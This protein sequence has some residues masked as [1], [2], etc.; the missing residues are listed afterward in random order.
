MK[1]QNNDYRILIVDSSLMIVERLN[2]MLAEMNCS[3]CVSAAFT[4]GE[5]LEKLS[6]NTYDIVLLDTQ[7]PG[8]NGFELLTFI[9]GNYPEMKTIMFTN[10]VS[11]FYR[12]KGERIGTDHFFDKSSDFEKVIEIV[13]RYSVG[14]QMN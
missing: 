10:Q 7:L 8:K 13:K 4:Y 1:L 12:T 5:A 9:K 14:Y 3:N 6:T 2:G 11:D